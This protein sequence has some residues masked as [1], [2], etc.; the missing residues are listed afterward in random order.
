MSGPDVPQQNVG[1]TAPQLVA[2]GDGYGGRRGQLDTPPLFEKLVVPQP[3]SALDLDENGTNFAIPT[4]NHVH[5]GLDVPTLARWESRPEPHVDIGRLIV[6][7]QVAALEQ[8]QARGP[9]CR[10]LQR[11][12]H[13]QGTED[14]R[15]DLVLDNP[16]RSLAV[17][18]R[19][20]A[21]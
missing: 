18:P 14:A 9:G 20:H 7:E 10:R 17:N 15:G 1:G 21:R 2:I 3:R 11:S 4:A 19:V 6:R 13:A 8:M 12:E 16:V 5:V